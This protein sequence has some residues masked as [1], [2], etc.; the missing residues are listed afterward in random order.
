MAPEEL[1]RNRNME[2]LK[3]LKNWKTWLFLVIAAFVEWV[4]IHL[5]DVASSGTQ[6]A[7][8]RLI[9]IITLGSRKYRDMPYREAVTDPYSSA[10]FLLLLLAT[11][12]ASVLL[13]WRFIAKMPSGDLRWIMPGFIVHRVEQS[14]WLRAESS[15]KSR[16]AMRLLRYCFAF[17]LL[18]VIVVAVSVIGQAEII[19]SVYEANRD[20]VAPYLTQQERIEL[21][22]QFAQT[23]TKEDFAKVMS[24]IKSVAAQHKIRL[25][26]APSDE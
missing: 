13:A 5:L 15:A 8:G 14:N 4:V 11:G 7:W 23:E 18:E 22:S 26:S 19:R 9:Q 21:Q 25:L 10:S 17:G 24:R 1:N 12:L 20:M 16:S 2:N 6:S 3:N